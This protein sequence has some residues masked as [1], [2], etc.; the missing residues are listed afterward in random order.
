[1]TRIT[2]TVFLLLLMLSVAP[3]QT[4]PGNHIVLNGSSQYLS[5][6]TPV[7]TK[8]LWE[9]SSR[10]V[11]ARL[12]HGTD[13]VLFDWTGVGT[14]Y[15]KAVSGG[16]TNLQFVPASGTGTTTVNIT[17]F[18]AGFIYRF[19][20]DDIGPNMAYV[21]EAW[22]ARGDPK[23]VVSSIVTAS[24][25]SIDP[26]NRAFR[27]GAKLDGTLHLQANIDFWRWHEQWTPYYPM[28]GELGGQSPYPTFAK[29]WQACNAI[30][31]NEDFVD[32]R[33]ENDLVNSGNMSITLTA[34]GSPGFG[35]N[36]NIAPTAVGEDA[37]GVAKGR[38]PLNGVRSYDYD[39]SGLVPTNLSDTLSSNWTC[40]SAPGAGCGAL[41]IRQPTRLFTWVDGATTVGTYTFTFGVTD[42][43]L[44]DTDTVTITVAAVTAS[45]GDTSCFVD[46]PCLLNAT[47]STG[48]DSIKIDTG[49]V[50]PGSSNKYE[51]LIP[52]G[53]HR[54]H[55]AGTFTATVTA[56]DAQPTPTTATDTATVTVTAR[57][58]ANPAN[59]EDLTNAANA[60]FISS[61]TGDPTGNA[62]KLQNAVNIVAARNT[63]PQKIILPAGCRADTPVGINMKVPAGNEMITIISSGTLPASHKRI[64]NSD[65]SQMFTI[66]ATG[67]NTSAIFSDTAGG[68]HHYKLRGLIFETSVQQNAIVNLGL[69]SVEDTE[70]EISHH[71]IVQH[72]II[73]PTNEATVNVSNSIIYNA[74]DVSIID[75]IFEP[76]SFGGLESHNT[77]VYSAA[78]RHVVNNNDF[79]GASSNLFIGGAVTAV[80]GMVPKDMEI[81][82]NRFTRPLVWKP[83]HPSWD[84]RNRNGKNA[85]ELKTGS[86]IVSR[87]NKLENVWTDGQQGIGTII[88][89][90]C[91]AGNWAQAFY[92]D[93][94][95][96]WIYNN[97]KA[98]NMRASEYRGTVQSRKY[99]F[100]HNLMEALSDRA[101]TFLQSWDVRMNHN[102][103]LSV[104]SQT[105]IMDGEMR[106]PG[107]MYENGIAFE[108]SFGW[109]GSGHGI[110]TPGLN[111]YFPGHIFRDSLQVGGSSGSYSSATGMQFP[112]DEATVAFTNAAGGV[113]SLSAGSPYKGDANDGT[114]PGVNWPDLQAHLAHTVDGAWPSPTIT[115][116]TANLQHGQGTDASFNFQRQI[117]AFAGADIIA[118]QERGTSETSWNTPMANAGLVQAVYLEN[119]PTEADGPA[120]WYRS[121]TVTVDAIYSRALVTGTNPSCG[122]ANAGFDCTTDVRK[123]AVAAK[124]TTQGRQF[125]VVSVHGCW[126]RCNNS[127]GTTLSLQ[128]ENQMNDLIS[129][130]AATLT[131]GLDV[132]ILGDM[133]FGPDYAKT[134]GGLIKDIITANYTDLWNAGITAG[135]ATA[136]WG[137]RNSDA[138]A[139]MPVG[140]LTTRTHD[141]RRI[142]YIFLLTGATALSLS[143][144]DVPDLRAACP[145]A[146]VA[147]GAMPSCSPEVN[148][149][150]NVSGQQ[151][152]IPDDFGVRPSD[153]NFIKVV[154]NVAPGST[155]FTICKWSTEPPCQSQ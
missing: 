125:Y 89:A 41:T 10:M 91:D 30:N 20:Y 131:G 80:R 128:R 142:D 5:G 154:L 95:Y 138:T 42:G 139:D 47:A 40:V 26:N 52:R 68:S 73:R 129:W 126:S 116:I 87:G 107:F 151:W 7:G 70:A 34:T 94:S 96:N 90:S 45:I 43:T 64:A 54:Y 88:Q 120:I 27:I 114:D 36:A 149:G 135:T 74:N 143:S 71:F 83:S 86:Y 102:T 66:R 109:F 25:T 141:T 21:L 148:G 46:E 31:G 61:C 124:V 51:M 28:P 29:S 84:S 9:V 153:H 14:L 60:N 112:A 136:D 55:S 2:S 93:F 103:A 62:T 56:T 59:T 18:T 147:G 134:T 32:Y 82:E 19:R 130:I 77:L 92:V 12:G 13:Q 6:T 122:V 121:A 17:P 4:P 11:S 15:I 140:D 75:G 144:I 119:N 69:P 117:D 33:F 155:G 145:H 115:L 146:L 105:A 8:G 1:M 76:I 22:D 110:G 44:T 49:E 127:S 67:A 133:N 50:I 58:E 152:D 23:T 150:P 24:V 118:V 37:T 53:V 63:V 108:G 57:A 38:I 65:E 81:N 132:V 106:G 72:F 85:W 98:T 3:A 101:Y 16:I 104:T 78:G 48:W 111:I 113:W 79:R 137:D 123:S 97:E 35:A 99:W 39:S 100:T